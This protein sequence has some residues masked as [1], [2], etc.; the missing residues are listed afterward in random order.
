VGENVKRIAEK[1]S[2]ERQQRQKVTE[3]RNGNN[4]SGITDFEQRGT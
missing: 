4:L 3:Q 1:E 2:R